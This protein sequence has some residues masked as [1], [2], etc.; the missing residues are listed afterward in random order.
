MVGAMHIFVM[1]ESISFTVFAKEY[2]LFKE[3]KTIST[4]SQK[5]VT[6]SKSFVPWFVFFAMI[7]IL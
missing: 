3:D 2:R 1:Y 4:L 6:F 7:D 5:F